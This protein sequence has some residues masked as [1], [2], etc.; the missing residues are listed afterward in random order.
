[1]R[2][3][4]GQTEAQEAVKVELHCGLKVA[5]G[6]AAT[7]GCLSVFF[8]GCLP[9]SLFSLYPYFSFWYRVEP[10]FLLQRTSVISEQQQKHRRNHVDFA[11]LHVSG[12]AGGFLAGELNAALPFDSLSGPPRADDRASL[13]AAFQPLLTVR[14]TFP[15]QNEVRF[16]MSA[17][18]WCIS[19]WFINL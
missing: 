15:S 2:E 13:N 12:G 17:V 5:S 18:V 14:T 16:N 1:M 19:S 8:C 7:P 6:A 11:D 10:P 9:V 3:S 4:P